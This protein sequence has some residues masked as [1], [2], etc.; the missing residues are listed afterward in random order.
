MLADVLPFLR[1]PHCD[2]SLRLVGTCLRC[3][4]GHAFDVARQGYVSLLAG[5]AG[6]GTGDDAA[7]VTAR[8]AFL[9]HYDGLVAR[10][11][12]AA[13]AAVPSGAGCV[14]DVGAGTGRYLAA[15][16]DALPDRVGIALDLSKPA[17]RRAAR[18]HPRSGAVACDVWRPWPLASA[19]AAAA[20]CV[21]APRNGTELRRVLQPGGALVVAAPTDAHLGELVD[22]LGLLRVDAR[23]RERLDAALGPALPTVAVER[24]QERL[25]L[26]HDAVRALVAMG[27]SARHLDP[28]TL[29]ARI[30]V[31]PDPVE[32]TASVVVS[33]HRRQPSSTGGR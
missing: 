24:W 31:L 16:L 12:A 27:P 4:E 9:P 7:M 22:A 30:A 32:V 29:R 6:A 19:S 13:V 5:D 20:L 26:D 3:A 18:A 25:R 8:E 14:V 17:L 21:F 11:A 2:R 10:V 15:V 1:C 28:D 23:K 33:T